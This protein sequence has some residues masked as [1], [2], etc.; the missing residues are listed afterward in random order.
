[1]GSN[2][3]DTPDRA[4]EA[5]MRPGSARSIVFALIMGAASAAAAQEV[6]DDQFDE[7]LRRA[8]WVSG[9]ALQCSDGPA[10]AGIERDALDAAVEI[11]RLFGTDRAFY[12]AAA[13]G[14]GGADTLVRDD[15]E[16][17]LGDH[18]SMMS[19]L[20]DRSRPEQQP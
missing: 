5:P 8:G 4:S 10:R 19:R 1:M 11:G 13:F 16:A 3:P 9:M 14:F 18:R 7:S 15:C 12:Y 2:L 17:F 6:D 20:R